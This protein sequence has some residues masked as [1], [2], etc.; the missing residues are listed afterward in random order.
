MKT[1]ADR[2]AGRATRVG[3]AGNGLLFAVK[4]AAGI[5][6]GS[7]ALV[8]DALNS[9]VDVAASVG[10]AYSVSVAR[11]AP[12]PGHP[13]GH[14]RAEPLAA[15]GVAIFT[16]ILGVSVARA[17]VERLIGGVEPI[18]AAGW[19]IAALLLSMAG[20]LVL[21]RY[22]RRRG[23]SLDSPAILANAVE[24]E[25][26]IWT[27][28]AALAGVAGA[29][30]GAPAVD[31]IAGAVVGV[32]IIVGGY[33]F[34]RRNIDY[35]MGASPA[36]TL[37][38][39]IRE[40]ALGISEVKGVHDVR[41]HYVGHRVHVE[42]H[43]EVDEEMRTRQSHDIGGAVRHAV[44]RLPRIDR[45]FVHV[46]PVL[47]STRVIETLAANERLASRIYSELARKGVDR[48]ALGGVWELLA[49]RALA[50]AE[51][52]EVVRRLKGAGWHFS[53]ADLPAPRLERRAERL[54]ALAERVIREPIGPAEAV[55]IALDLEDDRADADYAAATTPLDATLADSV[56]RS[57]P[58][59]PRTGLVTER[60][61]AARAAEN[62]ARTKARLGE[63]ADRI[64]G[65][66]VER[67]L[68]A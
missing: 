50:R 20:N 43:V 56:E 62:D 47:D 49:T 68:G 5:A 30:L 29:A 4:A 42:L 24:S 21:A 32:W 53:D 46:D 1:D 18:R 38:A 57:S 28:L 17:A 39:R 55:E 44:E 3:I 35:L 23:E 33:R 37:V 31:A 67:P 54:A 8:S 15:L 40:G 58:P 59:P 61:R 2:A 65:D 45:A 48:P 60:M 13:F 14:Q 63:L 9:L 52:L 34:G 26:D 12:D 51:R 36:P 19:A 27:S 22:L 64:G 11:R 10:I 7:I 41:A 66:R 6:T 16:A 25:N